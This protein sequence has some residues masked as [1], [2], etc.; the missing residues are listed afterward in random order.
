MLFFRFLFLGVIFVGPLAQATS[1]PYTINSLLCVVMAEALGRV[2]VQTPSQVSQSLALVDLRLTQIKA[3]GQGVSDSQTRVDLDTEH[4][5]LYKLKQSLTQT[6][7]MVG[8]TSEA[9]DHANQRY[10]L[11]EVA[12]SLAQ[13]VAKGGPQTEERMLKGRQYW[14]LARKEE[15]L[16]HIFSSRWAKV[17]RNPD[18]DPDFYFGSPKEVAA[19]TEKIKDIIN[20]AENQD[21]LL[22][23]SYEAFIELQALELKSSNLRYQST[24]V[25]AAYRLERLRLQ[26][27]LQEQLAARDMRLQQMYRELNWAGSEYSIPGAQ[28]MFKGLKEDLNPVI[29]HDLAELLAL[30]QAIRDQ[31]ARSSSLPDR[32]QGLAASI[33]TPPV[34]VLAEKM[35]LGGNALYEKVQK[36]RRRIEY[37]LAKENTREL[38]EDM[39]ERMDVYREADADPTD[40]FKGSIEEFYNNSSATRTKLANLYKVGMAAGDL[41]IF[42]R[43]RRDGGYSKTD[44]DREDFGVLW[45]GYFQYLADE[46]LVF[47]P[48]SAAQGLL[49]RESD[50]PNTLVVFGN[51]ST[52]ETPEEAIRA[53][54]GRSDLI[55]A[56]VRVVQQKGFIG[57]ASAHLEFIAE[58]SIP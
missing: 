7:Q 19:R 8:L 55:I 1:G 53:A 17:L 28:N 26:I 16:A 40:Y 37:F 36:V 22:D 43:I 5:R 27:K 45:T 50:K 41:T 51:S 12:T 35:G 11:M 58:V 47:A 23:R 4:S 24:E 3:A 46:G 33:R 31:V 32:L 6:G 56:N 9:K 20:R 52:F 21:D 38:I 15:K 57:H 54:S 25:V 42:D 30:K 14:K 29:Q 48:L 44:Q 13:A 2:E 39:R 18:L 49:F 10:N 34:Y